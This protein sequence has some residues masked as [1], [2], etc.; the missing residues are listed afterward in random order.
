[1]WTDRCWREIGRNVEWVKD[2]VRNLLAKLFNSNLYVEVLKCLSTLSDLTSHLK[3]ST[4]DPVPI[5]G[6]KR[7]SQSCHLIFSPWKGKN[8]GWLVSESHSHCAQFKKAEQ[9]WGEK[10]HLK[11]LLM[12]MWELN[13]MQVI[14]YKHPY[15]SLYILCV[16]MLVHQQ[17]ISDFTSKQKI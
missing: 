3:N 14:N 1:M 8:R 10:K 17:S 5:T 15:S 11:I 6:R 13:L 2:L 12:L 4:Q 9:D 7:G 16:E